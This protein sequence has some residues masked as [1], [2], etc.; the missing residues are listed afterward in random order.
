LETSLLQAPVQEFIDKV[1]TYHQYK[2]AYNLTTQEAK[3]HPDTLEVFGDLYDLVENSPEIYLAYTGVLRYRGQNKTNAIEKVR[4]IEVDVLVSL[5]DLDVISENKF[6]SNRQAL[7]S[8]AEICKKSEQFIRIFKQ[9]IP[10]KHLPKP[11]RRRATRTVQPETCQ[12]TPQE[13]T[14]LVQVN[15]DDLM[16]LNG[17][18]PAKKQPPNKLQEFN[19]AFSQDD[20]I[21][22]LKTLKSASHSTV[23]F[24]LDGSPLRDIQVQGIKN[25]LKTL[26]GHAILKS[27]PAIKERYVALQQL[28]AKHTLDPDG[29]DTPDKFRELSTIFHIDDFLQNKQYRQI[30]ASCVNTPKVN[31]F[32]GRGESTK[33]AKAVCAKCLNQDE[34][35]EFALNSPDKF[36]IWGG[37][38]E[39][40][41]RVVRGVIRVGEATSQEIKVLINKLRNNAG[42]E[43][44]NPDPI[45]EF[46]E[47]F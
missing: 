22:P 23:D 18:Q 27:D 34:C 15:S 5:V 43:P 6:E 1:V 20:E 21:V 9:T 33:E 44:E 8:D 35:L 29:F 28:V 13:Q 42:P 47:L 37:L 17:S 25:A 3:T 40:Q 39:K 46:D 19:K 26:A 45:E 38:S 41:R 16:G 10:K 12:Q 32:P 7:T 11:K 14:T 36:G 30:D 24:I 31:F 2:D 4:A